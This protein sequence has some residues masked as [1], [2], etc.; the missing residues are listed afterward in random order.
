VWMSWIATATSGR[1]EPATRPMWIADGAMTTSAFAG[2]AP[3]PLRT[4]TCA[5]TVAR[6]AADL[7]LPCGA[8]AR[9]DGAG[10]G[11]R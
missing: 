3:A 6:V 7:K 1:T 9:V 5:S 10:R 2:K 11:G 4:A 8:A